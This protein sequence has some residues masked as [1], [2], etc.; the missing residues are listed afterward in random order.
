ML[1]VP[2]AVDRGRA[3]PAGAESVLSGT[4]TKLFNRMREA[5]RSRHYSRRTEETYSHCTF[6]K[7]T[8]GD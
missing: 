5:L 1:G 8:Y 3:V 7:F 2:K 6:R 4:G